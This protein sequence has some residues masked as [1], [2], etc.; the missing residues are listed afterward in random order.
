LL[1]AYRQIHL[2]YYL[3]GALDRSEM[4]THFVLEFMKEMYSFEVRWLEDFLTA[5]NMKKM[6]VRK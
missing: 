6:D 1:V 5:L 2:F 3:N 4:H